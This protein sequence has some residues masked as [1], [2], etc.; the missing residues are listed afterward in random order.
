MAVACAAGLELRSLIFPRNC[1]GHLEAARRMGFACYRGPEP[2]WYRRFPR[3]AQRIGHVFDIVTAKTPP[4]VAPIYRSGMWNIPGSM[5]YTPSF[6]PRGFVPVWLRVLR[7]RRGLDAAVRRKRIF[8]LW[9]H[10]TDLVCRMDAMLD[11]LRRIFE[12]AA[13]L[14][15]SGQLVILPMRDLAPAEV[16]GERA[17]GYGAALTN[18]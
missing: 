18:A 13:R 2:H 12:H 6:G 7:G 14:R 3:S 16:A 5:L 17:G 8:H 11:G 15:D 4:T 10:P 1:I 9:F